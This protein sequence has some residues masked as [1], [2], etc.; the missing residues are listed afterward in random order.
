MNIDDIKFNLKIFSID[1]SH[2]ELKDQTIDEVVTIIT[3]NH[4]KHLFASEKD[5]EQYKSPL[6]ELDED[7]FKFY[8]YCYNEAKDQNYWKFF[9]PAELSENQNF[10]L[11]EFSHVIFISTNENLYCVTSGSGTNVIKKYLNQYFGI[12]LYQHF[13]NLNEDITITINTRGVTGNLSN[14]INTY[15]YNQSIRD[16]LI[17]SEI[18]KKLKIII[19][20]ELRSGLFKKFKLDDSNSIMEIGSYFSFRKKLNF[21]ELKD[22]ILIIEKVQLNKENYIN[23]SLFN[24]VTDSNTL[25]DLRNKLIDNIVENIIMHDQPGLLKKSN[26]DSIEIVN[27]KY[28]EKFYECNSF[29]LHFYK[30]REKN[31][32]TIYD[33]NNLYFDVTKFIYDSLED[34]NNRADI[35]KK[36]NKLSVKGMIDSKEVTFES[37]YNQIVTELTIGENKYFRIDNTWFKLDN[38]YLKQLR[39]EAIQNY[40][41]FELK[42]DVLNKWTTGDEDFYNQSH[43]KPNHYIFDKKISENIELCDIMYLE[44]NQ[45]YFIHVKN[46]FN[47]SMRNLSNQIVL[48][49][50]RLWND[51]NNVDG[52]TY[53]KSTIKN[54]NEKT[55]HK[56]LDSN[57]I[58]KKMRNGDLHINFVMAYRYEN[59]P[60]DDATGK[61]SKT[62]SNIGLFSIV[63]TV[64]EIQN[65]KNFQFHIKDISQV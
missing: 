9:L 57:K 15:N 37:F 61:L 43:V 21:K 59:Y 10:E 48:S 55:P 47:T 58:L 17:Y 39:E 31:D 23:L 56:K 5:F 41:L 64:R 19:R 51:I 16:S 44:D 54:Y 13:A 30:H 53:L 49:S 18:P 65:F 12:E 14:R 50:Q 46:G 63:Q 2:F 40:E 1:L 25:Q 62:K 60:N 3:T 35:I 8:S 32:L 22:L 34:T 45:I 26:F 33:R 42:I 4:K 24:R 7:D 11:I 36:I 52:S 38:D 29:N 28:L 27:S 6:G 20:K